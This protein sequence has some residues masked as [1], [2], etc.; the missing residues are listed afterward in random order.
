MIEQI[1]QYAL[2]Y[3]ELLGGKNSITFGEQNVLHLRAT[4][5]LPPASSHPWNEKIYNAFNSVHC[6]SR[7]C[8]PVAAQGLYYNTASTFSQP[9]CNIQKYSSCYSHVAVHH[10]C[11]CLSHLLYT[12]VRGSFPVQIILLLFTGYAIAVLSLCSSLVTSLQSSQHSWPIPQY[13]HGCL[14]SSLRI[15]KMNRHT[16][17]NKLIPCMK[18]CIF[19]PSGWWVGVSKLSID[20]N[21]IF[22]QPERVL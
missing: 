21:S 4:L 13:L 12:H 19:S 6:R 1:Q 17:T 18:L 14:S 2:I 20:F 22:F 9:Y 15:F 10:P 7:L 5:E 16:W 3:L 11:L 8:L